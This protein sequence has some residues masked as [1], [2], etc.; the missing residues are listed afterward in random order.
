MTPTN[1]PRF[2]YK[3]NL[4]RKVE[5]RLVRADS[6][7]EN[8]FVPQFRLVGRTPFHPWH[9]FRQ[10]CPTGSRLLRPGSHQTLG[11]WHKIVL[12]VSGKDSGEAQL[13]YIRDTFHT[14]GDI[15]NAFVSAGLEKQQDD[16]ERFIKY[17]KESYIP[18][19]FR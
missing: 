17:R 5:I 7:H 15:Y 1:S 2:N 3:R 10:Y 9:A 19:V 16:L 18:R 13:E 14:V 6:S 11:K 8:H 12:Y 4:G